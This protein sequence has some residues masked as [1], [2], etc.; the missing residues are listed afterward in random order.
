MKEELNVT[1]QE[2]EILETNLETA[3]EQLDEV[4]HTVCLCCHGI[5]EKIFQT[6]LQYTLE[7]VQKT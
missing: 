5:P 1:R 6:I 7:G 3:Q 2:K 4:K